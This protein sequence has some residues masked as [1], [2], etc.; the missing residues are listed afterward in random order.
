MSPPP[1]VEKITLRPSN[2]GTAHPFLSLPLAVSP[3]TRSHSSLCPPVG[4]TARLPSLI[5]F[6]RQTPLR[7]LL[8]PPLPLLLL[9][10]PQHVLPH[11]CCNTTPARCQGHAKATMAR[12][13]N[14]CAATPVLFD[15][16]SRR[17]QTIQRVMHIKE[18]MVYEV[19]TE[20]H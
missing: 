19:A 1:L 11:R 10:F 8:L 13:S 14:A 16:V 9:H 6:H 5:M 4:H 17:L 3:L 15:A 7:L 18:V 12:T 20:C 2:T